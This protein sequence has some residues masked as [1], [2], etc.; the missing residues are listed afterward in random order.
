MTNG[1]DELQIDNYEWGKVNYKL[2]ITNYELRMGKMNYKLII[3][4]DKEILY[5]LIIRNS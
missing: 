3:T 1:E 4:N 5:I 2:A